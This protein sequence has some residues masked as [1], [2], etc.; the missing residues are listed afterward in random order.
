MGEKA[1]DIMSKKIFLY[2]DTAKHVMSE[3]LHYMYLRMHK[4][5]PIKIEEFILSYVSEKGLDIS[6]GIGVI[7]DN[8]YINGSWGNIYSKHEDDKESILDKYKN[9]M[10]MYFDGDYYVEHLGGVL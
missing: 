8:A 1:E 7:T 4:E 3:G 2:G 10:L 9:G 5:F 6:N